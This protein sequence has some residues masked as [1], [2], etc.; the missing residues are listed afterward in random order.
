MGIYLDTVED[1]DELVGWRVED[2]KQK[3]GIL[4]PPPRSF[5]SSECPVCSQFFFTEIELNDHIFAEHRHN[6]IRIDSHIIRE[7]TYIN[8]SEADQSQLVELEKEIA[9]LQVRIDKNDRSIDDLWSK[10]NAILY[11]PIQAQYLFGFLEYLRAHDLEVNRH[12]SDFNALSRHFGT[13][14]GKLQPFSTLLAQQIRRT[15]AFKMNWF[16]EHQEVPESSLFFLAWH[17]FTHSY[18]DVTVIHDLPIISSRHQQGI[19]LDGFHSELLEAIQ[20]YYSD[21]SKL[22]YNWLN[23]LKCLAGVINRNYLDKLN[24]FQARLYRDWQ[25]AEQAKVAYRSIKTHPEFGMEASS[26]NG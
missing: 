23:K 20:L 25:N 11:S 8:L 6:Y 3:L 13:A 5:P 14:Y 10:Y 22:N 26:F 7:G 9:S 4:S 2:I 21:R 18:E 1:N 19:V 12:S 16:R 17:F 24:L 15:I